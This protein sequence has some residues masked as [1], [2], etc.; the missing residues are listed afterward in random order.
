MV[1]TVALLIIISYHLS[2]PVSLSFLVRAPDLN[3]VCALR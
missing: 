2:R 3:V 1:E